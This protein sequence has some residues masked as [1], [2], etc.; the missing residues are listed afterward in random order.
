[1]A[2]AVADVALAKSA[3]RGG[4]VVWWRQEMRIL[5]HEILAIEPR[6]F[7]RGLGRVAAQQREQRLDLADH[8]PLASRQH[9]LDHAPLEPRSVAGLA[10]MHG[11]AHGLDRFA[12]R[13][14]GRWRQPGFVVER[15]EGRRAAIVHDTA[16]TL[17][18]QI[19]QFAERLL[20][21]NRVAGQE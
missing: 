21:Q 14:I 18:R 10:E 1:A 9:A 8:R 12:E 19:R 7:A 6:L 17:E 16:D 5:A 15:P 11:L 2:P 13:G 3:L 4:A 20:E